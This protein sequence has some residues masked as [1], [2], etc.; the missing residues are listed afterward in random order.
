MN[1]KEIIVVKKLN[2][3]LKTNINNGLSIIIEEDD[4]KNLVHSSIPNKYFVK[5]YEIGVHVVMARG[6]P[7]AKDVLGKLFL[8][9][10][11]DETFYGETTKAIYNFLMSIPQKDFIE[12]LKYG[13]QRYVMEIDPEIGGY[14]IAN[15]LIEKRITKIEFE[16]DELWERFKAYLRTEA[17]DTQDREGRK[18]IEDYDDTKEWY[19]K[20][21]IWFEEHSDTYAGQLLKYMNSVEGD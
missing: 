16:N 2:F 3:P 7:R 10:M 8:Y 9:L 19:K 6:Y 17:I 20:F 13:L 12:G 21:D 1:F 15:M 11:K 4:F 14:Y 18:M 5:N